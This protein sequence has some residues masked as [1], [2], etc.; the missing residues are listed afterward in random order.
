MPEETAQAMR[1][2]RT[3]KTLAGVMVRV[4]RVATLTFAALLACYVLLTVTGANSDNSIA[5]FVGSCARPLALGFRTLFTTDSSQ[6]DTLANYGVAALFWLAAGMLVT[7][8][9]RKLFAL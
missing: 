5:A 8:S 1:R 2:N 6:V 4:T 9:I 7:R 3:A